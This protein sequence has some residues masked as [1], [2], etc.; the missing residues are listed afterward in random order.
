MSLFFHT[1]TYNPLIEADQYHMDGA[2]GRRMRYLR[3]TGAARKIQTTYR[4]YRSTDQ[5]QLRSVI[6]SYRKVNPYQIQPSS[7]RTVTFWRKTEISIQLQQSTGFGAQNFNINWGFAL[8]YC[9]G[10]TNGNPFY[11]PSVPSTAEFQALFDYYK[12]NAVKVQI[13]FTK[14]NVDIVN[15]NTGMPVLLL[16]NDFDDVN[17]VMTLN[18]M[19]QRVGVRHV[20]FDS[21]NQ[22]GITHYL[23][24]KPSTLVMQTDPVSGVISSTPSG[25]PFAS[26]WLDT[27]SSAIVHNGF[28]VFFDNQG[29]TTT[30]N[31]GNITFVFDIEYVFKGYR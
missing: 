28:K 24:P 4:R 13:F 9:Y 18:S 31:L 20:Q 14:T 8:G 12:I 7:G 6:R 17:E 10:Y 21:T 25:I 22:R 5:N 3:K 15:V 1:G 2:K 16:C 27:A 23:K 26:T 19:N 30:A 29:I 11:T